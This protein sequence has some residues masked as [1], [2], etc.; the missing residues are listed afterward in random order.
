MVAI[1]LGNGFE[2]MEAIAPV[3]ILR[4]GGVQVQTAGIGGTSIRGA[5][6]IT[7]EAEAVSIATSSTSAH[8]VVVTVGIAIEHK[9]I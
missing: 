3:D 8:I 5:H 9:I 1:L 2:E 4:R 7:V 6:G